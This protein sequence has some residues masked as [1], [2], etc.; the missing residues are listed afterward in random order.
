[1]TC[2]TSVGK[3]SKGSNGYAKVYDPVKKKSVKAHRHVFETAFGEIPEGL[4]IMHLCDNRSCTNLHHLKVATQSENLK[5]M[6][7]KGRQGK[8]NLKSGEDHYMTKLSAK[9]V[10]DFRAIPYYRGLYFQWAKLH[11]VSRPTARNIYLGKTWPNYAPA[12]MED[13]VTKDVPGYEYY[14]APV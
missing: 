1:M 12:D 8:R 2:I 4:V 9:D 13:L 5:D 11:G 10:E 3:A 6:Y 14:G 7:D